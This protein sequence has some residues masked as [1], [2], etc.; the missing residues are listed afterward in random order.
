[1]AGK[2]Y[3][4]ILGL[5]SDAAKGTRV[6]VAYPRGRK[7]ERL[8]VRIPPGGKPGTKLRVANKGLEGGNGAWRGDLSLRI[9]VSQ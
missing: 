2:D 5:R 7:Q 8:S 1:M 6:K 9:E 3:Y 4:E